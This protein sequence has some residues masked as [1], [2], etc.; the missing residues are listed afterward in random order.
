MKWKSS[1]GR[2][3]LSWRKKKYFKFYN[4][5]SFYLVVSKFQV[6]DINLVKY[7]TVEL[8]LTK[9]DEK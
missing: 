6:S 8:L 3:T 9:L 5:T 7:Y 4:K 1:S 2:L